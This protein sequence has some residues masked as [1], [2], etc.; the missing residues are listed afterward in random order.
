M[1]ASQIGRERVGFQPFSDL[2]GGPG[3]GTPFLKNRRANLPQHCDYRHTFA[4]HRIRA[5]GRTGMRLRRPALPK[6]VDHNLRM[7]SLYVASLG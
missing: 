5:L 2:S 7:R 1:E 6:T 3:S 4:E